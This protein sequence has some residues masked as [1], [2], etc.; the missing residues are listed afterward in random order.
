LL[1]TDRA[2]GACNSAMAQGGLQVALPDPDSKA[3]FV[4]DIVRSARV[5]LDE[6]LVSSF[7]DRVGGCIEELER[8]GLALDRDETGELIRR[9][10]GGLSDPR[11]V[12]VGDS[13]GPALMQVLHARLQVVGVETRAQTRV[14]RVEPRDGYVKLEVVDPDGS[15]RVVRAAAVVAATGGLSFRVA[16]DR[17]EPTTNPRNSN[18]VLYEALCDLGLPRVH[19]E[20]FQYQPFGIV[21]LATGSV[22]RCVPES[23]TNSPVRLLDRRG[24]VVCDLTIDRLAIADAMRDAMRDGR[25]YVTGDGRSALRLTLS[26]VSDDELRETFPKLAALLERSAALGDDVLVQP[27]LHYQLGGFRAGLDGTTAVPGL[28]L[29]GEMTGGLHGR[30]RLMGNGITDSLVRGRLS[31]RAA[32]DFVQHRGAARP[33]S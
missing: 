25:G 8:W 24:D 15:A 7:V 5:P 12:G 17:G 21:S 27:F 19:E 13:I 2:L 30:N 20:Y 32:A 1:I 3:R 9:R 16:G 11:I 33:E 18:H 23:I 28:F 26:D 14:V 29:A 10:A 22:G 6:A 4:A 31:G